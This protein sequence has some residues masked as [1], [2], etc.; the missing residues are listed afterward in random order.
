MPPVGF[1]PMISAGERPQ[2]YALDHAATGTGTAKKHIKHKYVWARFAFEIVGCTLSRKSFEFLKTHLD[3]IKQTK[4][5][6]KR[7]VNIS[8]ESGDI[9]IFFCIRQISFLS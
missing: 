7:R 2:I 6:R 8:R 5:R 4:E 9:S 3:R 1:K